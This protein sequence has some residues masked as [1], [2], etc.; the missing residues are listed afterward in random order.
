[1]RTGAAAALA[2]LLLPCGQELAWRASRVSFAEDPDVV[3]LED[4]DGDQ[5]KDLLAIRGGR[6][7]LYPQGTEGFPAAPARTLAAPVDGFLADAGDVDGDGRAELAVLAPRG[8]YLVAPA[9]GGFPE[10]PV[11]EPGTPYR[12]VGAHAARLLHDLDRDGRADLVLP[13]GERFELHLS[14]G[15]EG[16]RRLPAIHTDF[17]ASMEAGRGRLSDTLVATLGI[18]ALA[19]RDVNGDG[20][21]DVVV[22]RDGTRRTY[23]KREDGTFPAAPDRVLDRKQ[24]ETAEEDGGGGGGAGVTIRVGGRGRSGGG[25]VE[26]DLDGDGIVDTV[27]VSGR[28]VY[29]FFGTREGPDWSKPARV[30]KVGED[31]SGTVIADVNGDARPDLVLL[32]VEKPGLV[33]LAAAFVFSMDLRLDALAFHNNGNRDFSRHPDQRNDLYFRLPPLLQLL[34]DLPRLRKEAEDAEQRGA[35]IARGDLDGD[36]NP[37]LARETAPDRVDVFRL[38]GGAGA[39]GRRLEDR[40]ARELLFDPKQKVLTVEALIRYI[41]D[42]EGALADRETAGRS[43][44]VTLT[45]REP[46]RFPYHSLEVR[47]LDGDGRGDLVLSWSEDRRPEP[48]APPGPRGRVLEFRLSRK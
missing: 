36:G 28:T 43:P 14:R 32:K 21:E 27:L 47:D 22:E 16:F 23:L 39:G 41:G 6:I 15:A 25:D 30:L 17:T 46:G 44:D 45:I 38:P 37:D 42:L 13:L 26:Q 7:A 9:A 35:R 34:A 33:R 4:F 2:V 20:R 11:V 19:F 12:P 1:M 40:V 18:P 3:L 10:R 8:L 24:F 48:G 31:I 5:R 29:L